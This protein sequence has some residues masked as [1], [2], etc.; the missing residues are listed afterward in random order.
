MHDLA[1]LFLGVESPVGR[2]VVFGRIG[3]VAHDRLPAHRPDAG[4]F[5]VFLD[6]DA[7]AL[8]FGQVPVETVHL[9]QGEDV[10]EFFDLVRGPEVAAGVEHASAV[11][12]ERTV[13]HRH[14]GQDPA[15]V[16]DELTQALQ[17]V[18]YALRRASADR[19]ARRRDF[20]HIRFGG[21]RIVCRQVDGT[22][23]GTFHAASEHRFDGFGEEFGDVPQP[24]VTA[25]ADH[26]R[27][28]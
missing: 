24:G 23:G 26:G 25:R 4:Q 19:D 7:P 28:G 21:Q 12:E 16:H 18:E 2:S 27:G 17:A 14:G 8:I 22:S 15:A 9:V 13:F 6:F 11:P 20:E 1:D 5:G 3:V 10:D